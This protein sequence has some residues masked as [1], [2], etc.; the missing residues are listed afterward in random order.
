MHLGR[1]LTDTNIISR[2]FDEAIQLIILTCNPVNNFVTVAKTQ[3]IVV[4]STNLK[5]SLLLSGKV[6]DLLFLILFFRL[7]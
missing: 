5:S 4:A 6:V 3:Q 7:R 2:L 1:A